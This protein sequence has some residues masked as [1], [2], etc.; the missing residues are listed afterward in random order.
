MIMNTVNIVVV[1]WNALEYT[2]ITLASLFKN[3][4]IEYSLTIVDNGS[5]DNTNDFLKELTYPVNILNCK[6]LTNKENFGIGYAYNQGYNTSV[7]LGCEYTIF[8]N[9][10]LLFSKG[11]IRS[12]LSIMDADR[13]IAMANSI[14]PSVN[15]IHPDGISSIDK[16]MSISYSN[17][18]QEIEAFTGGSVNDF[19]NFCKVISK[20]NKNISGEYRK[21]K[22]PDSLSSCMCIVRNSALDKYGYFANPV[23]DNNYG[24]EDID[25]CWSLMNDGYSCVVD[26]GSYVHHFRGKSM[27]HNSVKVSNKLKYSNKI[28]YRK[29]KHEIDKYMK[30]NN[31]TVNNLQESGDSWLLYKLFKTLGEE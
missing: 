9:N 24:G 19:D 3:T 5:D 26:N 15:D 21:I 4:E 2:K 18:A 6:V 8:C 25:I 1:C 13:N 11:W 31:L 10:D 20:L 16:L 30:D 22:F 14:R 12:L 7:E 28:L 27:K 23:F 17:I 29:W